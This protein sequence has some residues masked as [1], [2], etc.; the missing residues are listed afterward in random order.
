MTRVAFLFP[1][2]GSQNVGMGQ[3]FYDSFPSAKLLYQDFDRWVHVD[4]SQVCFQGPE[5]SLKRTLYTQPAILA[6]SLAAYELFRAKSD[7]KPVAA[8]GHSLGEY[9]ALYAAGVIDREA[10]ARLIR[11]RAELMEAAPEGAMSAVLGLSAEAIDTAL[12]TVRKQGM[13]AITVANY[14]TADQTVV[15]GAKTAVE[16]A[17]SVLKEAGAKRVIP[18]P[19]GGAFHS[20]LMDAAAAEFKGFVSGFTFANA[21]FPVITNVDAKPTIE[22]GELQ[23]KLALQINHSVCWAQTMATLVDDHH[24][25]AVIEFGPGKVLTGMMRKSY[26]SVQVYNVFDVAS[27]EETLAAVGQ[28]AIA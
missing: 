2:Q 9:G 1:G 26:P 25:E 16:S 7:L 21:A 20:P 15:S 3:D 4:L 23:G 19:V 12:E 22:S 5:E 13:G 28:M 18:L 27:L 24:V 17:A 14:N 8:A 10:A 11:K 6:T